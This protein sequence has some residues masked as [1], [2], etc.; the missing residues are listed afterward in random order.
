MQT[1]T[2]QMCTHGGVYLVDVHLTYTGVHLAH[3]R[4]PRR[5]IRYAPITHTHTHEVYA[6]EIHAHEIHAHEIHAYEVHAPEI[7]ARITRS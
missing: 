1:C 6:H 4:A 5:R 2:S 3:K 7:H